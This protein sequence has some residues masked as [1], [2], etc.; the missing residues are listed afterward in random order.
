MT[1]TKR[2]A[3]LTG[4]LSPDNTSAWVS[5]LWDK[6]NQQR[7]V[8]IDQWA[9]VDKYLTATDTTTTT[10]KNLPWTHKTTQPKLTQIRDNLHANYILSLFPNDKWLTWVAFSEDAAKKE[11]ANTIKSY[12]ENKTREGGFRDVNSRLLYDYIDK[13]NAFAMPSFEARYKITG[14]EK[15]ASFIGPKAVRISPYDIVFNPLAGSFEDTFKIVRTMTTMGALRKLAKDSPDHA[16]WEDVVVRREGIIAA[17]ASKN[18]TQDDWAKSSQ[19]DVDGFGSLQEYYQSDSVEVLEFYGDFHNQENGQ[20]ECNRMITVV[21]RSLV[22]RDEAIPSYGGEALIRHVGWR[23]RPDN[24]WA[25]GPLDNLVGMQYLLDHYINMGANALDLKVMPPK[26]VIGDVEEFTWAPNSEIHIDENGDVQEMAQQFGDVAT[27]AQWIEMLEQKMELYAG[28]PREA[29]GIRS[30]GEKT[31]LEVQTLDQASSRIFSEKV[32]QY[33]VFMEQVLN[34]MLEAAHRNLDVTDVIRTIDTDT[35]AQMFLEVTKEDI[36]AD[37]IIRP[38]GARHFAQQATELQNL[39]GI[40]NSPAL[41]LLAPHIS[42][43]N[44]ASF[45]EDVVGI[46]AYDIFKP[47]VALEEQQEQSMIVGQAQEDNEAAGMESA[48]ELELEGAPDEEEI[49]PRA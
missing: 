15:T 32:I 48:D 44:L 42:G 4:I 6:Y 21:D 30:P 5:N 1:N 26:K 45:A 16:F 47:W 40:L 34:D 37:G 18:F 31:A 49:T 46:T 10:N 19:Y 23:F 24:L 38:I 3:E 8:K 27:V 39:M 33:E 35:G 12:M 22:A 13:G 20:M 7:A 11:K 28:A 36:V 17:A 29:M 43:K 25:M 2:V 9:E 14:N 41:Q